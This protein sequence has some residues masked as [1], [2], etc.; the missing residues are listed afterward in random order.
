MP[1]FDPLVGSDFAVSAAAPATRDAAGFNALTYTTADS[2]T[3]IDISGFDDGWTTEDNPTLCDQ[4]GAPLKGQFQLGSF[5][6][7]LQYDKDDAIHALLETAFLSG[8]ANISC[9]AVTPRGTKYSFESQVMKYN[10]VGGSAGAYW[11]TPVEMQPQ[12]R[13]VKEDV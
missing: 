12:H 4:G 2:C 7:T 1:T 5:T 3:I 9:Q 13:F 8:I 6:L 11:T 10:P